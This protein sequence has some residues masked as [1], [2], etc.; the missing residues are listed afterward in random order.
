MQ[1]ITNIVDLRQIGG[2]QDDPG[3]GLQ[4]LGE[5]LVDFDFGTD[6]NSHGWFVEN[7][8]AS[9]MVQP[10]ADDDLLLVSTGKAGRGRVAGS[11]FD[12][13]IPDLLIGSGLLSDGI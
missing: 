8:K 10:F 9:P 6:V 5:K 7:K 3:T 13:H 4:Q 12:L 2:D 1:S 11:R